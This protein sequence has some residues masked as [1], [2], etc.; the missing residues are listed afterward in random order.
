M[1]GESSHVRV[2]AVNGMDPA[3]R[4]VLIQAGVRLGPVRTVNL[5]DGRWVRTT[6]LDHI[7]TAEELAGIETASHAAHSGHV[8]SQGADL[9]S[10]DGRWDDLEIERRLEEAH[11]DLGPDD[12]DRS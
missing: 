10:P 12:E 8:V 4:E 7:P 3:E 11:D 5:T 9:P 6:D 2:L 1:Q